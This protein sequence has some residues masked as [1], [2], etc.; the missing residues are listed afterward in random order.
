LFA[1]DLITSA[2]MM[3]ALIA[4]QTFKGDKMKLGNS[5]SPVFSARR[6]ALATASVAALLASG[7]A[8]FAQVAA[9]ETTA[10]AA[11]VVEAV[12]VT[13]SRVAR[14]GFDAPTPVNVLGL[15]EIKASAPANIADFVNTMPSVAG[16]STA[17]NSSGALSNGAAGISALE[18]AL[19]GNGPDPGAVRRPA[20][21]G[22]GGHG[23][24][25]H[26]HLP[27]VADLARRGGDGRRLVGLRL[28]RH[29]RRGQ[30]HPRQG[31]HRHQVV[32]RIR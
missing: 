28:G 29:R 1:S 23:P 27:A 4:Y 7:H 9:A 3:I 16:S 32:R 12:I 6:Y 31:L 18:P 20:L 2:L 22:V 14:D 8:A 10:P 11:E 30:L 21:G 19:A 13:G 26:Q 24:G 5:K 25:R 15:E 17:A